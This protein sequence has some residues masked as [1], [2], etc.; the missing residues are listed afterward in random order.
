VTRAVVFDLWDTV[1]A[2]AP[3]GMSPVLESLGMTTDEWGSQ[4]H[5]QRRWTRSLREFLESVSSDERSVNRALELR[6]ELTRRALVPADGAEDL[7]VE[8]RARGLRLGLI[9]NCSGD[10]CDLWEESPFAD[11]FDAVVLSADVG[12]CKPDPR[13]YTVALERLDADASETIFVGDG[14]SDE[15]AGAEAVGMRAVL[16]GSGVEWAGER[17]ERLGDLLALL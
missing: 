5:V 14:H 4:E 3:D 8:L 15:L 2:W 11:L 13:I 9:S 7:L 10:V 12:M 1:A 16:L 6:M 17:I